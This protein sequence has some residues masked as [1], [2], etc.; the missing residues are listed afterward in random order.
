M[1]K[2]ILHISLVSL[3]LTGAL[4]A[5]DMRRNA[6]ASLFSDYKASRIGDAITIFVVESSNASNQ[7]ATQAGRSSDIGGNFTVQSG[8][9]PSSKGGVTIGTSNE[10]SGKGSTSSSGQVTAKISATIDSVLANGNLR[11][12]GSRKIV[13]NGEEQL[14][15]IS[16]IVRT[17]DI[18]AD[19]AV[20][21]YNISDAVILFEGNGLIQ[22]AQNPGWLTKLA[23][24]LF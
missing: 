5:Q 22:R 14:I 16:G 2:T 4:M 20:L 11:I 13:I 15:S 19:N 9:T 23:H 21:S 6:T 24:W 3:L 10:F 12:K 17:S 7:A 8:L 1:T 18:S